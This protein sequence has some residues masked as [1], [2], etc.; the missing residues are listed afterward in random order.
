MFPFFTDITLVNAFEAPLSSVVSEISS[1]EAASF[2]FD[3]PQSKAASAV[4]IT[5]L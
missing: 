5:A 4:G 1:A 2:G 3:N